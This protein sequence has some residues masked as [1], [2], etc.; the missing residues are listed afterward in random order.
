MSLRI[1]ADLEAVTQAV[2][3]LDPTFDDVVQQERHEVDQD[4]DPAP[5]RLIAG[6]DEMIRRVESGEFL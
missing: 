6:Y 2:R 4:I 1:S 3:G 5:R